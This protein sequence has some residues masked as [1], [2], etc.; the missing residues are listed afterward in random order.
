MNG[1]AIIRAV[2]VANPIVISLVANRVHAG[3]VPQKAALPALGIT[4]IS[5]IE[6]STVNNAQASSTLVTGRIQVTVL[7]KDYPSKEAL[8]DVVRRACNYQRGMVAGVSVAKISR[9]IVGPDMEDTDL[10]LHMKTID[11]KVLYYEPNT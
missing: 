4:E 11:F 10:G 6:H 2:L 8:L 7:A 5:R 3:T 1:V 9:D